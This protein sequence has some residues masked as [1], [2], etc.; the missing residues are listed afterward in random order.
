LRTPDRRWKSFAHAGF[1]VRRAFNNQIAQ[2]LKLIYRAGA[3][4][5]HTHAHQQ[6]VSSKLETRR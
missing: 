4:Q 5:H 3:L 6:G 1:R 2:D